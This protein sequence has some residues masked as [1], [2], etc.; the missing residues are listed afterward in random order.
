MPPRTAHA[1]CHQE[2]EGWNDP[3]PLKGAEQVSD[4]KPFFIQGRRCPHDTFKA[5][6]AWRLR[7]MELEDERGLCRTARPARRAVAQRLCDQQRGESYR[8]FTP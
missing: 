1:K 7:A 6:V 2:T 3:N 4:P 5:S 8:R